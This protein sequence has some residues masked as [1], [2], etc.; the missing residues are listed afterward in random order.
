MVTKAALLNSLENKKR[1]T[2]KGSIKYYTIGALRI[3]IQKDAI[4][5]AEVEAEFPELATV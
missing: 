3:L 4:T 2:G 1:Q 5:V